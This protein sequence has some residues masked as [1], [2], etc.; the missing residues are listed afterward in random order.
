M[1]ITK[2]QL[3]R[4]I[5]EVSANLDGKTY[6]PQMDFLGSMMDPE[7]YNDFVDQ[8]ERLISVFEQFHGY[9]RQELLEALNSVSEQMR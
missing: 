1:K 2:K 6:P 8:I 4:I 3:K 7:H 9:T 5:K